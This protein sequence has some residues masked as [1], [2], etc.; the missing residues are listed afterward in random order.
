MAAI[1]GMNSNALLPYIDYEA[2]R[3]NP[4]MIIGYSDVTALLLGIYARTGL[5]TYYGPA[6]VASFGELPPYVD[7][8]FDYFYEML[9]GTAK[10]PHTFRMPKYW[11]DEYINWE[12]Q[13]VSKKPYENRW[14]TIRPGKAK[15]CLVGGNL[16]TMQGIW[17]R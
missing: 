6:M 2:L 13:A 10:P 4:K 8:T 3:K 11:T 7:E 15:G 5:V 16:N 1:G 12:T 9:G 14:L 17:E